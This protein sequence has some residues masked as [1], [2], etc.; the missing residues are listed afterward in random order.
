MRLSRLLGS[1]IETL[2]TIKFVAWMDRLWTDSD[3][4]LKSIYIE[5]LN[6]IICNFIVTV[7]LLLL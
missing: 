5:T 7:T 3:I 4:I 2:D 1:Y 6:I